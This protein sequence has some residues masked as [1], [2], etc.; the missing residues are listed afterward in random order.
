MTSYDDKILKVRT[1]HSDGGVLTVTAEGELDIASDDALRVAI[2]DAAVSARDVVLD[3]RR[4]TF[5][6]SSGIALILD[7][8]RALGDRLRLLAGDEVRRVLELT[9]LSRLLGSGSD[10]GEPAETEERSDLEQA[11]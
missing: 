8:Q 1:T 9:G 11:M 10:A 6:G 4:I 2:A 3:L 7:A 5:C